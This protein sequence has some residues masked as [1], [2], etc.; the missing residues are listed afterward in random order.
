MR[1]GKR[2]Q[3]HNP[4]QKNKT[5]GVGLFSKEKICNEVKKKK[6][7]VINNVYGAEINK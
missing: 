3:R 4:V 2:K 7:Y 1:Y 6:N 5:V